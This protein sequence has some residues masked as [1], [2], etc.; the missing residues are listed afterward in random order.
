MNNAILLCAGSS[1][2]FGANKLYQKIAGQYVVKMAFDALF[3][4]K[5]FDKIIVVKNKDD[6]FITSLLQSPKTVFVD[7][8]DNRFLSAYLGLKEVDKNTDIVL[9]QDGARPFIKQQYIEDCLLFAFTFGS[10]ITAIPATDT[11]RVIKDENLTDVLNR[12]NVA[13]I[14]TPQAFNYKNLITAYQNAFLEYGENPPFSDDSSVYSKYFG[15]CKMVKGDKSNVKITVKSDLPQFLTG[16]GYDI[17][18]LKEGDGLILGGVSIPFNKSFVAHSD[19]DVP[20]HA[21]MDAIL[22]ALGKKDIGHYF[23]VNDP[24]YDGIS[25]MVLLNKVLEIAKAEGK[26]VQNVS[27]S[28][29]CENPKLS[30]YIDE[31]KENLA[32]ALNISVDKIGISATTNEKTGLIG[33]GEAIAAYASVLLTNMN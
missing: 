28:I 2:R 27:I 26:Q 8:G 12:D 11:V 7:G 29:I 5:K 23:P 18:S 14:Q 1:T 24:K 13:L 3:A 19:G 17:H 31:M 6:D 9:I 16:I 32:N 25:S 30:P 15:A 33:N 21:L 4:C 20:V 10:G 22:S